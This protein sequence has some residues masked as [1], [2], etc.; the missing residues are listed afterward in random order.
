MTMKALG[1]QLVAVDP[2]MGK[3]DH[4]YA[5]SSMWVQYVTYL[6][7][8][9]I[10]FGGEIILNSTMLSCASHIIHLATKKCINTINPVCNNTAMSRGDDEN[11]EESWEAGD[12]LG[13]VL[14]L[15]KQVSLLL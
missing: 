5:G 2:K 7:F 10:L 15:V 11:G 4:W 9:F 12:L 8:Y 1:Q 13:K 6:E 14:T 3:K